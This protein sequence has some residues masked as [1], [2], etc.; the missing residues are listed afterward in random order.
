MKK[1][2]MIIVAV[3]AILLVVYTAIMKSQTNASLAIIGGADG[4]T[5]IF[6]AGTL[7]DGFLIAA[8]LLVLVIIAVGIVLFKKRS[9]K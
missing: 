5:A 6:L 4:P 7:G 3:L 8:I 2:S 9:K 1:K